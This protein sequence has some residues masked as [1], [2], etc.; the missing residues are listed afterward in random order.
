M[1]SQK[2]PYT[3]VTATIERLTSESYEEDDLSGIPDLVEVI[4]LQSTGPAEAAR[5]I[6]KK[7]K[8]GSVH[9]QLRALALLDGLIQNAGARFQHAFADEP[10]LERLRVCGTSDLSDPDVKK[11]CLELFR[12][13]TQYKNTPGL[14]RV[15]R[16][17]KELPQ[18]K[19]VVTQARSKVVQETENPFDDDEDDEKPVSEPA[20]AAGPSL[21]TSSTQASSSSGFRPN[22]ETQP[23]GLIESFSFLS[24][25]QDK[26]K[27]KKKKDKASKK[28][29]KPFNLEAEKGLMK[30]TIA[31]AS[32][33]AIDLMNTLQ[34]INREQER[35][36]ENSTALQRF[37]AAKLLR[38][39]VLR[40]IYLVDSEEYL[41][42]L[43][44]AND[45]LVTALMTFEQLDRSID[46]DSDSDDDLAEQAHRYR[47]I[48]E[49]GKEPAS[50]TSASAVPELGGLSIDIEKP[51][52]APSVPKPPS[53][54]LAPPRP[55]AK[56][57]PQMP[58]FIG[59][60]PPPRR[61]PRDDSDGG[62]S[63]EDA[64]DDENDPFADRHEVGTPAVETEEPR[65]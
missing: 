15:A 44:H 42:S 3:A 7:L 1:F 32:I 4:K 31:D 2:K 52:T 58:L 34:S 61:A 17:Y 5:A 12:N 55:S 43:L 45:E 59:Q 63:Y 60:L 24:S 8:Y 14:E 18:R 22:T 53:R 57:K 29:R 50:P 9:R 35:I 51:S 41:G 62:E 38:R 23:T 13:W 11:K 10:L 64:D 30:S 46:A 6:R 28:G 20:P 33:A 16:L 39:K 21:A 48:V 26:D 40:Y 36:S 25:T 37:E 27:S 47:M 54:P 19:Q 49:K 56:S 65:W